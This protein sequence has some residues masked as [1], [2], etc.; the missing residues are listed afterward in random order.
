M[1]WLGTSWALNLIG[2]FE[3]YPSLFIVIF[4]HF[5]IILITFSWHHH[6][7]P[8]VIFTLCFF[9][10]HCLLDTILVSPWVVVFHT[11]LHRVL[12][13]SSPSL[14]HGQWFRDLSLRGCLVSKDSYYISMWGGFDH[15]GMYFHWRSF[16][17]DQSMHKK[18]MHCSL[19][20]FPFSTCMDVLV[21]F[22]EF[23][24]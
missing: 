4:F 7:S 5:V 13:H 18:K 2:T 20:H 22:I 10:H 21:C 17:I 19:Y 24:C 8:L 23:M 3:S 6:I 1:L 16:I 12:S 9:P 14:P 15:L 11:S